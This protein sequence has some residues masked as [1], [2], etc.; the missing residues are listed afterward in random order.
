M[1]SYSFYKN[2]PNDKIWWVDNI[3][4][5][6]EW[7]FSFDRNTV[8]NLFSDYPYKLTAEQKSIF[9]RENPYWVKFFSDRQ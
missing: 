5:T 6:G 9:D 8:F 4:R 1:E 7:L 2:D 3:E